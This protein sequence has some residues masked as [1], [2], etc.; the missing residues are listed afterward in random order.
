[1]LPIMEQRVL[2]KLQLA[3]NYREI[4]KKGLFWLGIDVDDTEG[5]DTVRFRSFLAS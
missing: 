3:F 5:F 1:M 2:R 4:L